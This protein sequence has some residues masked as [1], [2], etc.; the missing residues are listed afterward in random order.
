MDNLVVHTK[1]AAENA[2]GVDLDRDGY[3]GGKESVE[4]RAQLEAPPKKATV[5][6]SDVDKPLDPPSLTINVSQPKPR[7]QPKSKQGFVKAEPPS[8]R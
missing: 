5:K 8:L 1:N 2:L 4:S 3:V 7:T 6:V